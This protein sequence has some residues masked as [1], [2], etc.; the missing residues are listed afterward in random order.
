MNF[1][2]K[3]PKHTEDMLMYNILSKIIDRKILKG[4]VELKYIELERLKRLEK[5]ERKDL[6]FLVH[7]L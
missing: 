4:I 7:H 5:L 2:T 3:G 6:T 1:S